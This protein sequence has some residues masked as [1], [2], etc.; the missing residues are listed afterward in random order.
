MSRLDPARADPLCKP[1]KRRVPERSTRASWLYHQPDFRAPHEID[2]TGGPRPL[3]FQLI[4]RRVG[5]EHEQ[6]I[7]GAEVRQLVEALYA[8]YGAQFRAA[9]HGASAARTRRDSRRP[10]PRIPLLPPTA[11]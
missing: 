4:V 9:R 3:P 1:T 10:M 2:A 8:I 11:C 6:T 5:R 7:S